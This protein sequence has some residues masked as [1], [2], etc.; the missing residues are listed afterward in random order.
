VAAAYTPETTKPAKPKSG[1]FFRWQGIFALLFFVALIVGFWVLFADRLIKSAISEAA[2]KALGVEVAIDKLHLSVT[3]ASFEMRGFT[4]AHPSDPM[5]NVLEVGRAKVQLEAMPLLRKRIVISDITVDSVRAL[6]RR[7]TPAKPVKGGGFLPGALAEANRFTAQFKVPVLSLLPIDTIRSLVLD[8]SQLQTVQTAKALASRADSVKDDAVARFK[9]LKL[10]ETADSAEALINRLKGQTPR[11]LGIT[12]TRNAVNDVKRLAAR[13]DE[14]KR[15]IDNG[16]TALRAG[17]DSLVESV[18][19]LDS[20]RQA[21]YAM[22]RGLLKL[23]TF[24]APNIGPALFGN[25]TLDAFQ[26][27]MYW[28]DLGRE[29]AP[30]GLLPKE[31]P[32]PKRLRASGTMVHF[33]RQNAEPQFYLK[34]AA[35]NMQLDEQTGPMRGSYDLRVADVTSDPMIVKKPI[36]FSLTRQSAKAGLDSLLIVGSLDHTRSVPNETIFLRAGGIS[37]PDF[38][39]PSVPLRLDL[40]KGTSTM[41]FNVIG[42]SVRGTL[43]IAARQPAWSRDSA[44]KKDLNT[45]ESLVTRVLTG[46]STVTVD[47]DIRGSTAKPALVVRSN[48]DREVAD[49]IKRVAGEEISKAEAKVRAQVDA[50]VDQKAAE[51]K[52]KITEVRG[53]VDQRIADAQARLDK[54]KADLNARLKELSAGLIGG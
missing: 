26:K 33:A 46:I 8:P 7:R 12:G 40:G 34:H 2:T 45:L 21:D 5:K 19:Q 47:A 53:E 23:P 13:V 1:G 25:V 49:N 20:A 44:R 39:L 52:A 14:T 15:A 11:S 6:T 3:G 24:D 42:D 41:R 10:S 18:K 50:V 54:A 30:P 28:I 22:A 51:V 4:V 37:L 43:S 48:L 29:Y 31:S 38:A 9:A 16:K 36:T 17:A 35:F 27:A 32:G